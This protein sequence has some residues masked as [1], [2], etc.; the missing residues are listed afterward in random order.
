MKRK[1]GFTL[2]E[3]LAVIVILAI[4]ALIATPIILNTINKA[5]KNAAKDSML[6]YVDAIESQNALSLVDSEKYHEITSGDV[7]DINSII[8]LKGS[9][10]TSGNVT[11][12][13]GQVTNATLCINGYNVTYDGKDATV[14]NSCND[15]NNNQN[16]QP[17]QP[18]YTSYSV[19]QSINYNPGTGEINCENPTSTTGTKEGCMK[20]YVIKASSASEETVDVI[21]DH[22]TTAKVAYETSGTYKEYAQASIKTTVDDLVT[23]NGW[24]VTPRLITANEIAIITN[25]TTFDGSSSKLFYFNG[26]G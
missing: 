14:G 23:I 20:W 12:E 18:T 3:L 24:Q 15:S 17:Q 21:L 9:K 8:K 11:I 4:I 2:I 10:P 6:G 5:K 25:T 1:N 22:N 13:K 26:T 7:S 16:E 19:G